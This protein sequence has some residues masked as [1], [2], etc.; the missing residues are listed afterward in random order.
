MRAVTSANHSASPTD[1]FVRVLDQFAALSSYSSDASAV[2]GYRVLS[3]QRASQRQT[4][5]TSLPAPSVATRA[6]ARVRWTGSLSVLFIGGL[7][8]AV[9]AGPA[10]CPC[11]SPYAVTEQAPLQRL[12][13]VQNARM[14]TEREL[15]TAPA[16]EPPALSATAL[17][18]PEH[19][20][21]GVSPISTS[22]LEPLR[23]VPA[24]SDDVPVT[25]AGRLPVKIEEVA[26]AGPEPV[27][28]ATAS[29]VETDVPPTLP[30]IEVA[31]PPAS[32]VSAID[33]KREPVTKSRSSKKRITRAYRTPSTLRAKKSLGEP[34][35]KSPKWAQQMFVTPWQTKAFSYTQ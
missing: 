34:A 23:D 14:I 15:E 25:S 20:F 26:D 3:T 18:E 13:Y 19:E 32:D 11:T 21:T 28:L 24:M 29:N 22:A 27:R 31:A 6:G 35:P 30:A 5:R 2:G 33:T 8:L 17:I 1:N 16:V 9:L 7:G 12:G 10:N 4:L